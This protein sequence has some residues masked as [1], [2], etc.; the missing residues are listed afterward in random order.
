MILYQAIYKC[1]LCGEVYKSVSTRNSVLALEEVRC[2]CIKSPSEAPIMMLPINKAHDCVDG[3][4]GV[5]D[6]I[7]F[8][9]VY[10]MES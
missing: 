4:V 3:S 7:G 8:K 2:A 9:R 6:F 10:H 1:R 5:A